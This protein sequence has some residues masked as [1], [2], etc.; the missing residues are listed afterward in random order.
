MAFASELPHAGH[1]SWRMNSLAVM[2]SPWGVG[3]KHSLHDAVQEAGTVTLVII[4][5]D[6]NELFADRGEGHHAANFFP[7]T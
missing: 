6:A 7:V 2:G 3:G 1:A 5:R 4:Q